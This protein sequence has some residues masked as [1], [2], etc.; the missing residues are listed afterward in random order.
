MLIQIGSSKVNKYASSESGDTL[1]LI[2]RPRGGLS[3]VLVDGQRSGRSAKTISNIVVRKAISLLSEGVRDGAAAR[4][5]HDYLSTH[6][7][8]KVS[9]ELQIISFDLLTKSVVISRNTQCPA[10]VYQKGQ[11]EVYDAPSQAIGIYPNTKP[12]I[13]EVPLS[14][15]LYVALYTDGL[16]LAAQDTSSFDPLQVVERGA[17]EMRPAQVLA[18]LLL[19]KALEAE[20]FRPRDDISIVVCA[21]L[22]GDVPDGARR[23]SAS[24]PLPDVGLA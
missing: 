7:A 4:A 14:P 20:R 5:A 17:R 24:F 18:D 1:E 10:L 23:L 22:P 19:Q 15:G 9:A 16:R 8:G 2:E 13:V 11:L 6:R 12:V 3:V 21:L